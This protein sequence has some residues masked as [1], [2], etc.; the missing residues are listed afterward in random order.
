MAILDAQGRKIVRMPEWHS[1]VDPRFIMQWRGHWF[2]F[3]GIDP[4]K[5]DIIFFK[6]K[7]PTSKTRRRNATR[8]N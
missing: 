3:E 7:E 4:S 2:T 5:P 1:D 8:N 6:Y